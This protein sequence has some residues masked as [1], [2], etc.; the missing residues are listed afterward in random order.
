VKGINT[1]HAED[2]KKLVHLFLE[3]KHQ[4]DREQRGRRA[5]LVGELAEFEPLT[6][7]ELDIAVAAAGGPSAWEAL[8]EVEQIKQSHEAIRR[9]TVRFGEVQFSALPATEKW[10]TDLFIWAGCCMHKEL[11]TVK[12]GAA[13]M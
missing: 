1:D 13:R 8:R 10:V 11:N 2:Q 5:I 9:A 3:T 12:G 4:C 6:K 7:E